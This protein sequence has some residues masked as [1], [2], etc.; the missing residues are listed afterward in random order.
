MN[1]IQNVSD[2][3]DCYVQKEIVN[4]G[5]IGIREYCPICEIPCLWPYDEEDDYQ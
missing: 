1:T 5:K 4:M 2:C 3:E